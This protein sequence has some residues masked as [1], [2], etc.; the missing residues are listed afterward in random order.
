MRL[1]KDVVRLKHPGGGT[2]GGGATG[3][4]GGAR[5]G[6]GSGAKGGGAKDGAVKGGAVK[7]KVK[8]LYMTD[9]KD[10]VSEAKPATN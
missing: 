2:G 5:A 3:G 9:D 1:A 8:V 7:V 6:A 10:V 4:R